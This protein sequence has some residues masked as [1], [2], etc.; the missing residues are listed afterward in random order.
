MLPSRQCGDI[1]A[2]MNF[3]LLQLGGLSK[4]LLWDN[5]TGIVSHHQLISQAQGWA[6][7]LGASVILAPPRDP[8]TKGRVERT[9]RFVQHSFVPARSFTSIDDFNMQLQDWVTTIANTRVQKTTRQRPVDLLLEER[10]KLVALPQNLPL[11]VISERIRLPRSYYVTM[12]TNNYSVDPTVIGRFVDIHMS[13]NRVQ[14]FCEGVLAADHARCYG[15]NQVRIDPVHVRKAKALR[16]SFQ[17]QHHANH[18]RFDQ[19]AQVEQRD[20]AFY[21]QLYCKEAQQ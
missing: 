13:L 8:E 1:L 20:L 11:A 5:E 10:S 16:K 19:L 9:N 14:V 18:E 3:C 21:D 12:Q 7:S 15:H 17:Q 2:G 6:G 4:H